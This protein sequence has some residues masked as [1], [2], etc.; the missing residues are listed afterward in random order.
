MKYADIAGLVTEHF[1]DGFIGLAESHIFDAK[2]QPYV[3]DSEKGKHELAKDIVSFLNAEGGFILIG[4]MTTKPETDSR[5]VVSGISWFSPDLVSVRRYYDIIGEWVYPAPHGV[6]LV[7]IKA[8]EISKNKVVYIIRI[9]PQPDSQRPFIIAKSILDG[10]GKV[11]SLL[12]GLSKRVYDGTARLD[13]RDI[14]GLL[15]NGRLFEE[16]L[17]E[18]LDSLVELLQGKPGTI[19]PPS[20]EHLAFLPERIASAVAHLKVPDSRYLALAMYPGSAVTIPSIFE[21]R[22]SPVAELM[23]KPPELR[24]NGWDVLCGLNPK[25]ISGKFLRNGESDRRVL[26][27]Y[28]D[29]TVIF[30]ACIN[31]DLLAW[32]SKTGARLHPLALA[33]SIW[34]V[35][36]FYGALTALFDRPFEHINCQLHM[37]NLM[38]GETPTTLPPHQVGSMQFHYPLDDHSSEDEAMFSQVSFDVTSYTPETAAFVLLKAIYVWFGFSEQEMPYTA[39]AE[40]RKVLNTSAIIEASR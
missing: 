38:A 24:S 28:P 23:T 8:N 15:Q 1:I 19:Q 5:E 21:S 40:G 33:E 16:R 39:Q 30:V 29:G 31:E 9:P 11:D 25:I 10:A 14:H 17:T 12:I 2:S 7:E 20:V 27:V 26:D 18:R 34:G 22:R 4:G 37:R 13:K 3:L 32:G 35:C 6:E 36:A